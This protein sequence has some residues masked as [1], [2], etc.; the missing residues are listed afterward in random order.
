MAEAAKSAGWLIC[1]FYGRRDM[2]LF[3]Y[4]GFDGRDE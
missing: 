3:D 1:A 2:A 4:S